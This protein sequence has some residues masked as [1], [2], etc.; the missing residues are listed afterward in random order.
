[1]TTQ[2]LP[3]QNTTSVLARLR[4]VIPTRTGVE[5]NEALRIAELHANRLLELHQ[6]SSGPVASDLITELPKIAIEYTSSPVSGA[7]F[8]LPSAKHWVIQINRYESWARKRFTLA[9]EYKHIIDHGHA[10]KLYTGTSRN[11]AAKQREQ[12][13]DYFA[14]CLL[15]PRRFLKRAWGSGMQRVPELANYFQ[16][17]EHA[18]LVRLAQTGL[19]EPNTRCATASLLWDGQAVDRFSPGRPVSRSATR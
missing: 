14:G 7:S 6:I 16:V 3:T 12:A 15:V 8:W 11:S 17:S 9:H 10:D 13:A 4:S 5:S 19:I 2:T 18:I 1:M